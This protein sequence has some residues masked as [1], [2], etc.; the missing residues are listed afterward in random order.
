VKLYQK[1]MRFL[2]PSCERQRMEFREALAKLNAH[3]EDLQRTMRF[4]PEEVTWKPQSP[5][6]KT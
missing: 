3:A 6:S 5:Q 1:V 2:A 4:K